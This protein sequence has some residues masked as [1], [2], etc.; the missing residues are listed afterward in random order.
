MAP[1]LIGLPALAGIAAALLLSGPGA[2]S[3]QG[4]SDGPPAPPP[5]R[6]VDVGGWRLH[7]NC[8]GGAR[9]AAPTVILE[10]GIGDFSVEWSLVQPGVAG[11]ARVCSYDRAGDG[12]S[13]LGPHPRTMHQIVYELHTLLERAG[14]RP[15][16][17]LVGHSFGG[18][19]V[20]LYQAT[21][22]AEV[23]GLV[24]VEA[25][26]DN[27]WRMRADGKLV[28]AADLATG[29]PI[30]AIQ[31]SNP[32]RES[33]I[34][35]AALRQM[36][37]G[38]PEAGLHANDPPRDLLP[39]LAQRMRTWALGQVKHVAAAVN[40]FEIEELA[41]LRAER[42][43][44]E[45]ALG[46]LPLVVLTRG[47]PEEEGPDS[48]AREEDHRQDHAVLATLSRNGK[49]I[50]AAHS[51]HHIQLQEPQLVVSTIQEVVTAARK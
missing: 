40:P 30:P 7:L 35:P 19:L 24:L 38:L 51:G 13:D 8:T 32:L 50:I 5:G 47:L 39:P 16:F 18:W 4:A 10:A 43:K 25:G 42:M 37:A 27:P 34:P 46:D 2:A 45:H 31:T 26:A 28:R 1:S 44:S 17:V 20:R 33:D 21:Y 36:Q 3:A 22:P 15:P 29:R 6:L 49:Q 9:A 12:W 23:V 48:R 14:E 11:F 41:S